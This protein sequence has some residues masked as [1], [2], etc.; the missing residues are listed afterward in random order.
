MDPCAAAQPLRA[1]RDQRVHVPRGHRIELGEVEAAI[2]SHPDIADAA[3]LVLGSGID[4]R[5]VAFA[6][7][8]PGREPGA[9]ALRGHCAQ[10]LPRYLVADSVHFVSRLPRTGNGKVDRAALATIAQALQRPAAATSSSEA[11]AEK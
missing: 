2:A 7:P 9:L 4:A 1:D 8:H 3:A 10:R 11:Q 6:V 5:L